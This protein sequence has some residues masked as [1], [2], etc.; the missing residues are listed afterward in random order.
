VLLLT[1]RGTPVTAPVS[2]LGELTGWAAHRHRRVVT[3]TATKNQL[4]GQLDRCFP[5]GRWRCQIRSAPESA[6]RIVSM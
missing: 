1:R 2:T 5:G 4:L 3:R 6:G